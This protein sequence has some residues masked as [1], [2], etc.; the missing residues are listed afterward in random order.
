MPLADADLAGKDAAILRLARNEILARRG[1]I[2]ADKALA[3][4]FGK[5]A[6]YQPLTD[7]PKLGPVEQ[8]NLDLIR[9]YEMKVAAPSQGFIFA[10]SDRRLLTREEV[11]GLD[12][13]QLRVN[14]KRK[15]QGFHGGGQIDAPAPQLGSL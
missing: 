11:S 7:E 12:K 14:A 15:A 9:Q 10:D 13:Q 2:F 4:H 1:Q 6:W 5:F 8:Q 3:E